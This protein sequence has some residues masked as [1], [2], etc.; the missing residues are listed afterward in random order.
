MTKAATVARKRTCDTLLFNM[1]G[2]HLVY[3]TPDEHARWRAFA[4]QHAPALDVGQTVISRIATTPLYYAAA[5]DHTWTI[6][7]LYAEIRLATPPWRRVIPHAM[8]RTATRAFMAYLKEAR[9]RHP[10][11]ETMSNTCIGLHMLYHVLTQ[12]YQEDD[13]DVVDPRHAHILR[14]LQ[15]LDHEELFDARTLVD[16]MIHH[17]SCMDTVRTLRQ[18]VADII[19]S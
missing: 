12:L 9:S 6:T 14:V 3:P 19:R 7:P 11:V 13:N 17:E 2:T 16:A 1:R 4:C 10:W 5:L 18:A 8:L 15:H